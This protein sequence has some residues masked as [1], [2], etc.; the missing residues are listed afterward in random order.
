MIIKTAP[1]PI[2]SI[3]SKGRFCMLVT[4]STDAHENITMFGDVATQLL[5][6]MGHSGTVPSALLAKDVPDA[7]AR[8]QQAIEKQKSKSTQPTESNGEEDEPQ[9]SLVH[10]AIPLIE[11]LQDAA[12]KNCNVLWK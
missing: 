4:F 2:Y 6:M 1:V 8:L 5:K 10:R 11:L 3:S 7:L 9:V 12:N